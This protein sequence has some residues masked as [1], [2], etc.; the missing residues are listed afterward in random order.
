[1]VTLAT[2]SLFKSASLVSLLTL[3]S[4]ITGLVRELLM[5]STF[6][7]SA[8]TDAFNVAFRIPNLLRRLFAE[9]AFSQ[10]FVPVL[11]GVREKEGDEATHAMVDQIATVLAWAL[12]LT[13]VLGVAGAPVL[14]WA[15]A[16]GLK[17]SPQGFEAA[18]F[19]TRWMFPYIAFMSLVALSAGVLNTWKRF[20]VPAATPVLLNVA[21]ISA[22]YWGAPWFATL[23]IEPIYA[24][25]GGVLLGGAMQLGVQI[26]V[27]HR[28]GMLPR[29]SFR[30]AALM[31]AWNHPGTRRVTTLMLPALLGVSVAQISLLINTQIASHLVTGSVSWLTYADRLMEFPTA[32]LGVALGVVLLPQ[33]AAARAAS[34]AGRYSGLL[35][36]GL[37]L[38]VLLAVPSAVALLTFA[39]PLVAVLY[40]Y[41]AFSGADVQQTSLALMGYGVGL[42]G[43]IAIK[44][45]AP[46]FYAQQDIRTPV[47]IAV[48]VLVLTQC[49]N[50]LLVPHLA[51]AGLALAI[52]LGAMVNA[53]WLLVGLIMRGSYKPAPG[54]GRFG[55]QVL[56]ASTLLAV[57]LTWLASS[58]DWM[59][60][61]GHGL[62]RVGLITLCI[63]GAAVV[64]FL[65]LILAGVKLRQFARK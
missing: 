37:R 7:A 29:V 11:A 31:A 35:D 17:Q 50:L 33:L 28:L 52:G 10:A 41:G 1:V 25:A 40:H 24:M 43:L 13:C 57:Y 9:G 53:T 5:A 44:V 18:V 54:W 19:M 27:L 64:Y 63:G 45:L 46:G 42:L 16:S 22:A 62:Q 60:F 39:R 38:V 47:K 61:D 32:M 56:G 2:V 48:V 49:L 6:G 30:W 34:D 12:T 23:G 8:L 36:W 20:A 55:L 3:A 26:P 59:G 21:M 51:H 65:A 14:V 15:M 58:I 4:R